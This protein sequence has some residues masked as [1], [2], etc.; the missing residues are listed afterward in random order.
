MSKD[1]L[2]VIKGRRS[3]RSFTDKDIPAEVLDKVLE[4]GTWAPSAKG[5]QSAVIVAVKDKVYRNILTLLNAK[6][7][8]DVKKDPYYGAP[9]IIVVLA[10]G[11]NFL[12]DGSCVLENMMLEAHSLGL[13]SVWI[14]R[15]LEIFDTP[16]GK[17][18][19]LKWNLPRTLRGVG[20]LAIGY[21][22]EAA[23]A[24]K[25]RKSGYIVRI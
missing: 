20:A 5:G 13:G 9:V 16:E 8:G 25:P 14:N 19:L 11:L 6:V 7:L 10:E 4:A 23:P 22:A 18:L 3:I 24:A 17:D 12:Q 15:E 2:E 1:I 21:P